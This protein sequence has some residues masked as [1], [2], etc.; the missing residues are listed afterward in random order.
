MTRTHRA[1]RSGI[2]VRVDSS[3]WPF[4][5]GIS[6]N[7]LLS[8]VARLAISATLTNPISR[9][10]LCPGEDRNFRLRTEYASPNKVRSENTRLCLASSLHGSD[11]PSKDRSAKGCAKYRHATS[12]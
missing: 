1:D 4:A 12:L 11:E 10:S 2:S 7:G 6:Y 9:A 8:I 5:I 3:I